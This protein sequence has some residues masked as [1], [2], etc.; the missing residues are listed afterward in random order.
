MPFGLGG[1]RADMGMYGGP[2]THTGAVKPCRG[3]RTDGVSDN[4]QDQG[5]GWFGL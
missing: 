5:R 1:V 2:T 3:E 4:P